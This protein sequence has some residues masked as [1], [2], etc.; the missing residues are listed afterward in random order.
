MERIHTATLPPRCAVEQGRGQRGTE[1]GGFIE[2]LDLFGAHGT[3][4]LA[5]RLGR[6]DAREHLEE[7]EEERHLDQHGQAGR[8][9]VGAVLLVQRHLFLRHGL[10]GQ[11]VGL[12]LVLVLHLLQVRLQQLHAAL[13]LDLLDEDGNQGGADDQHESDDGQGP[14]PAAGRR[15]ADGAQPVMEPHHDG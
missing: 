12:A 11:L 3:D 6:A 10:A 2:L 8:E 1:D 7:R 15:H 9:R 4:A 5:A 14:G 13:G